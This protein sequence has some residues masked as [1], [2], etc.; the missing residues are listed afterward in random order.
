MDKRWRRRLAFVI[1]VTAM[2]LVA[3]Q[4]SYDTL[5][6]NNPSISICR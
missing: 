5:C 6:Y 1:L 2:V 3:L 4:L